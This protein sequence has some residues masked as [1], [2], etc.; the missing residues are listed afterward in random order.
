MGFSKDELSSEFEMM[1]Q[2]V[3][4]EMKR[5]FSPEFLNRIDDSLVFH[6]LGKEEISQIIDI[7]VVEINKRMAERKISISL[8]QSARELLSEKGFDPVYNARYMNQTMQRMVEDPL[9]EELLKG[10]FHDGDEIM[11]GKKGEELTFSKSDSDN[12]DETPVL[13]ESEA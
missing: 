2:Q 3:K 4:D 5:L 13:S 9:A 11:V 7:Q 6:Q 10:K 12:S 1:E 8:T